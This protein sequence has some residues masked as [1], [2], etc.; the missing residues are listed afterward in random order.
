M[1]E[2]REPE[3]ELEPEQYVI[4]SLPGSNPSMGFCAKNKY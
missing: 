3:L 1:I 4:S 2:E